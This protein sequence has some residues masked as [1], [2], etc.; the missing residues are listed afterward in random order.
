[1]NTL[2][3]VKETILA[4]FFIM[5][6]NRILNIH[7]KNI[8]VFLFLF[9]FRSEFN[10]HFVR[11]FIEKQIILPV[12]RYIFLL[13]SFGNSYLGFG[14]SQFRKAGIKTGFQ[15]CSFVIIRVIYRDYFARVHAL[16]SCL[17]P[18]NHPS[19]LFVN[20]AGIEIN[21]HFSIFSSLSAFASSLALSIQPLISSCL[22][23]F[24][25]QL[26]FVF[27]LMRALMLTG[28]QLKREIHQ[29]QNRYV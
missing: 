16:K 22:C 28:F 26:F 12:I 17:P 11:F 9:Q 1:M 7:I 24:M 3:F 18:N 6:H 20:I 19:V 8:I 10:K 14:S 29:F 23:F 4:F 5:L 25:Q 15:T 13:F 21:T 2:K 27:V